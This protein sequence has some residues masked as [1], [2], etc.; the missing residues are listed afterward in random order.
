M[1]VTVSNTPGLSGSF[2]ELELVV[3]WNDPGHFNL[4]SWLTNS[5]MSPWYPQGICSRTCTDTKM[6]EYF[7]GDQIQ[8]SMDIQIHG[9]GSSEDRPS[10]CIHCI[11]WSE[12]QEAAS[13]PGDFRNDLVFQQTPQN[14]F[15]MQMES[16]SGH[17]QEASW[18]LQSW[19]KSTSA[20]QIRRANSITCFARISMNSRRLA[21]LLEL[22]T[23][24][25]AVAQCQST[26][27]RVPD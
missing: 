10:G 25:R 11:C 4:T 3:Y 7:T 24:G 16:T 13:C 6:W 19:V 2:K 23:L 5:T 8:I 9:W 20:L 22:A 15:W 17:V 1:W 18:A 14:T 12:A 26:C 21:D 27:F